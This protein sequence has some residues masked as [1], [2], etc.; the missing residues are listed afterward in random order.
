MT[1][2]ASWML[3]G[4]FV[5]AASLHPGPAHAAKG[6]AVQ[7]PWVREA[8]PGIRLVAAY[9]TLKNPSPK[10]DRLL[11]VS[12]PMAGDIELHRMT[13]KNGM[14]DMEAVPFITVPAQGE[15]KL[16]PGGNHL[17]IYGLKR[18]MREGERLP[19]VLK[20]EHAGDVKVEA[21]IRR[22]IGKH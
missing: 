9:M 22:V 21:P 6:I 12:S 10:A 14:M 18:E 20:F 16:V 2:F 13:V 19:L 8:P 17:M 3:G 11:S 7:D 5:L 1:K 15:F 4:S